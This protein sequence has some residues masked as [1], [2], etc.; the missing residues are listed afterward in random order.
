MSVDQQSSTQP[1]S[2]QQTVADLVVVGGGHAGH[3]AFSA[4]LKAGGPG[5]V[6]L[7]SEDDTA[8]YRR[9][10]LSKDFLRGESGSDQLA[11]D[12]A[13]FYTG[14][15]NELLLDDAVT[16]IDTAKRMLHTRSGREITYRH[17]ILATGSAP[18][19]LDVPGGDTATGLRFL[20][21]ARELRDAAQSAT[22][23]VVIGSGFIGCEASASLAVRGIAVTLVSTSSGPQEKRLGPDA[24]S[25]IS[26]WL[27]DAGVRMH[28]NTG[29]REIEAGHVVRLTDGTELAADLVLNATGVTLRAELAEQAGAEVREGR[30][31]VDEQMRTSV[32]G[33]FAVG[34]VALAMNT[35]AGR[36]LAVEHWNAAERMGEVAGT[37]AAGGEAHWAEPLGFFSLIGHHLLKYAAW[38]DGFD[39]AIPVHHEGG[40]LTVWYARDGVTVGV[41][42]S[43]A[44]DDLDLGRKLL[45]QGAPPPVA[46]PNHG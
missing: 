43:E 11:M 12:P 44:D 19:P 45:L 40:G 36:H 1:S 22:T 25:L 3:S 34:D 46:P 27:E 16:S 30:V 33:L 2:T 35:A 31:V 21:E 13:D 41:L 4:Y 17:C 5:P 29:V 23:A 37:V 8:P 10:P 38:A 26:G 28:H 39:E 7:I 6:I 20:S 24:S 42:T 14:G 15:D 9:P 18:T 32:P